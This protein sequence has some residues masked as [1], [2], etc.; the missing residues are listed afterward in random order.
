MYPE[1]RNGD[2]VICKEVSNF[3]FGDIYLVVTNDG[4]ETVK[5]VHPNENPD[6]VNLVPYNKAIPI[7]PIPKSDIVKMYKVKGVLKGY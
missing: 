1:I 6:L 5:Y 4:Q 7:T 2:Y 3:I